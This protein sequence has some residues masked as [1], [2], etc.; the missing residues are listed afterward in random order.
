M[1][2]CDSCEYSSTRKH[3]VEKHLQR[4]VKCSPHPSMIAFL[5]YICPQCRKSFKH[6]S[7][8]YKHRKTCS[9]PS[10][11]ETL[12]REVEE[13]KK[14]PQSAP[15]G[16]DA[17]DKRKTKISATLKRLVWSNA[18]GEE[19]GR[20]LCTCCK[21]TH[22]TQLSFVAGHVIAEARGGETTVHNLRPICTSCNSSMG[23]R[24]MDEFITSQGL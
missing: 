11:L 21:L 3:N 18:F 23:T 5:S 10:E 16:K 22:I 14:Q 24:D 6:V 12:K 1:Y 20:A 9:Q 7:G 8:F 4:K 19:V 13:L 2:K 15:P 17:V